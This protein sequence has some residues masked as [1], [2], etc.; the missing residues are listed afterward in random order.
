MFFEIPDRLMSGRSYPLGATYDGAGVN[1]AVFSANAE[2]IQLCVFDPA[3]RKELARLPLPDCTDEVWHGYL[4][5]AGP[6]MLYGYRAYGPY[7]PPRGFASTTISCCWTHTLGCCPGRCIGRMRC[8]G[9]GLV[10][11]ARI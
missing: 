8:S 5:E 10:R 9:T 6:G 7:D 2:K 11:R 1:F 3:G 4:P